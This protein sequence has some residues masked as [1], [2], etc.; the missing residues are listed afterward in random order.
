MPYIA[1]HVYGP[2]L[3]AREL[4][5]QL[6]DVVAIRPEIELCYMGFFTTCFELLENRHLEEPGWSRFD[7]STAPAHAGPGGVDV[8]DEDSDND[9]DNHEGDEVNNANPAVDPALEDPEDSESDLAGGSAGDSDEDESA[10]E[11][12]RP[13]LK[14]REILFYDDK[15]SIFK[16]RHGRL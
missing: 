3:N 7:T 11:K 2:Q 13:T 9:E 8:T 12:Q 15:V 14:L 6:V 16:A 5:L 10:S 1:D 4:A